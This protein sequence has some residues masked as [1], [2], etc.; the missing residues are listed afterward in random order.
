MDLTQVNTEGSNESR[1]SH[2]LNQKAKKKTTFATE[3]HVDKEVSP[4]LLIQA[5]VPGC[6]DVAGTVTRT[7]NR[8]VAAQPAPTPRTARTPP[9]FQRQRPQRGRKAG[10][11]PDNNSDSESDGEERK[12][13]RSEDTD[14]TV[15][16][17]NPPKAPAP[18]TE[19][20]YGRDTRELE[21]LR[22]ENMRIQQFRVLRQLEEKWEAIDT[23]LR[24][25]QAGAAERVRDLIRL[26]QQQRH[27]R[28]PI[29][30]RVLERNQDLQEYLEEILY[31]VIKEDEDEAERTEL[32]DLEEIVERIESEL[33]NRI[34]HFEDWK[35]QKLDSHDRI[36][37][38]FDRAEKELWKLPELRDAI[39][40]D[41]SRDAASFNRSIKS[42]VNS[43]ILKDASLPEGTQKTFIDHL[44]DACWSEIISSI[45]EAILS[46]DTTD[47]LEGSPTGAWLAPF[48]TSRM[49][50]K[51]TAAYRRWLIGDLTSRGC[52]QL[53]L[54]LHRLK[55]QETVR[56]Y[57]TCME[58]VK[59][60]VRQEFC[61]GA[62]RPDEVSLI[63]M[64]GNHLTGVRTVSPSMLQMLGW[65][66]DVASENYWRCTIFETSDRRKELIKMSM[67]GEILGLFSMDARSYPM[68]LEYQRHG[69]D[70]NFVVRPLGELEL[71]ALD[72][73]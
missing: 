41:A 73:V 24:M 25:H 51:S 49:N 38:A 4:P 15:S 65:F 20:S 39:A 60:S 8:V 31:G 12:R 63:L 40:N 59:M 13:R 5:P 6:R 53:C 10:G 33:V 29:K 28:A 1:E 56:E 42:V 2:I 64:K 17:R 36:I 32:D 30:K 14:G 44:V 54:D 50:H 34:S 11:G 7:S 23:R 72:L 67:D 18:P 61:C 46:V 9:T 3:K 52:R 68:C 26:R 16:R 70:S 69:K 48:E 57:R 22:D 55:R 43:F 27:A 19:D 47:L 37:R 45:V 21:R 71:I 62:V 58:T 66:Y 35:I